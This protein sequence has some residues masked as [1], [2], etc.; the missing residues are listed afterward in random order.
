V[1][2]IHEC[3]F[4]KVDEHPHYSFVLGACLVPY[5]TD[6]QGDRIDDP[7]V[8]EA[9]AHDFAERRMQ[10]GVM[11]KNAVSRNQASVVESYILRAPLKIGKREFPAGAW[12]L[13]VR[14]RDK[15]LRAA[16]REG[17][18]RGFSI[19]GVGKAELIE[20]DDE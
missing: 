1:A 5:E 12:M 15:S 4:V 2:E 11:H 18:L 9:A 17:K 14:V 13:G 16:I 20:D 19:G 3:T 7:A 6:F 8:I 10:I